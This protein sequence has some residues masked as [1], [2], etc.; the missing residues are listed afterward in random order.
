MVHLNL[1]DGI[2]SPSLQGLGVP[3]LLGVLAALVLGGMVKGIVSIGVPLVAMPILS[4]F[5]PIKDA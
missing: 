3:A 2:L 4:Q 1:S 5:L